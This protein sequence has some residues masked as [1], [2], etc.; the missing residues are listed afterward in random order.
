MI[1][2]TISIQAEGSLDYARLQIYIL[3]STP[4]YQERLLRP[5]ILVCPGGGYE[6]TSDREAEPVAMRLLAM[7]YHVGI[8]RYSTAP[9][10]YPTAL[11]E[12]AQAMKTVHEN[13]QK[14]HVNIKKIFV[15]GFS[16]GAH[17][18]ASLGV[19]WN[20]EL[21][22]KSTGIPAKKL[23]PA[24][25][26]LCYPVVTSEKGLAHEG[27]FQNL[28]GEVERKEWEKISI[29]K[30]VGIHCPPC[31]I[32]HTCTDETVPVENALLLFSA[33]KKAGV[34]VELH[35]YPE[36]KHGLSLGDASTSDPEGNMICESVQS[37]I[38]LL[39]IW[40]A[41]QTEEK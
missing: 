28:L 20:Q 10:K 26:I 13:A 22:Y 4:G 12:L 25:M 35:I 1:Y 30:Q 19:S 15:Q 9:A 36:G 37:W 41:S 8:L 3:D 6:H 40:L 11:L 34:S 16:A 39:K 21:V 31:F 33:L 32:W 27:S 5:M 17:L 38:S 7:G 23:R 24:G 18:A 2:D 14:W 29:E